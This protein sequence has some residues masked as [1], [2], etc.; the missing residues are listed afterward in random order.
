MDKEMDN[1]PYRN[2]PGLRLIDHFSAVGALCILRF[3]TGVPWGY[4]YRTSRGDLCCT[5]AGAQ[6]PLDRGKRQ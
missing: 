2:V 3:A 4:E 5:A 1:E 6:R